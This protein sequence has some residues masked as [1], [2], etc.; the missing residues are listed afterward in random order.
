MCSLI[1]FFFQQATLNNQP[2]QF[3]SGTFVLYDST[4]RLFSRLMMAKNMQI[5]SDEHRS[6]YILRLRH[7]ARDAI[8]SIWQRFSGHQ[9]SIP[10]PFIYLRGDESSHFHERGTKYERWYDYPAYGADIRHGCLPNYFGHILFGDRIYIK[11]EEYGLQRFPHYIAH[12]G[13]YFRSVSQMF[14]CRWIDRWNTKLCVRDGI[15]HEWTDRIWIKQWEHILST[16]TQVELR[17]MRGQALSNGIQE[18]YR[19]T[20]LFPSWPHVEKFR[21]KLEY[22]YGSDVSARKG[23]EIILTTEQLLNVQAT[24]DSSTDNANSLL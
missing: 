22:H 12:A 4:Q 20:L 15:F 1:H 7:F 17:R 8:L 6:G 16:L 9:Y 21:T 19:Q 14:L 13:H 2:V 24:C 11:P 3:S 18:I 23:N 10:L 5:H